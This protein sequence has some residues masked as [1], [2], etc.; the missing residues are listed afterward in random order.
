MKMTRTGFLTAALEETEI[1]AILTDKHTADTET[2]II[3]VSE[4]V[5]FV[6]LFDM[7][8]LRKLEKLCN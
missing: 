3:K 8:I 7:F 5:R 2:A 4:P 6:I 1:W